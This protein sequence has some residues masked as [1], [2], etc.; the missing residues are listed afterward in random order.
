MPETGGIDIRWWEL[1]YG[2]DTVR[3]HVWDFADRLMDRDG[4]LDRRSAG[5]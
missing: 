4:A 5:R 3:A 1:C 2:R